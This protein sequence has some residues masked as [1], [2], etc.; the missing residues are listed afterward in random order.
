MRE[1]DDNVLGTAADGAEITESVAESLA[2]EAERGYELAV[3]RPRGRPP[4]DPGVS[5]RVTFRVTAELQR[6]V[7]VWA[8]Q[9]GKTVSALARDALAEYVK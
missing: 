4:L 3:G 6:R 1:A 8:Q 5:P 9:E 7:L 2:R